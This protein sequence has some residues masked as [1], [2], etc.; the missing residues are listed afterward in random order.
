[1]DEEAAGILIAVAVVVAVVLALFLLLIPEPSERAVIATERLDVAV[2]AF[3]NSS[4]WSSVGETLRARVE[5]KLVNAEGISVFSRVRLDA[6]LTEQALSQTGALD[7]S[8]AVRIGSLTG[9]NKLVAGSVYGVEALSEAVTICERWKDGICVQS[10]PG[11]RYTVKLLAQVE[12]LN[13][14]TGRIEQAHDEEGTANATAKQGEVFAGYDTLIAAAADDIASDVSSF[15]T[16]TYTREIRYGLYRAVKAKGDGFVGEGE[17]TR[18]HRSDAKA[19][20][21][22]HFA[23]VRDDDSFDLT[24]VDSSGAFLSSLQ[25]VVASDDWRLYSLDL[26]KAPLGRITAKGRIAGIDAFAKA[27]VLSP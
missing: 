2:L 27:F 5:T 22:V 15:L 7:P 25:D 18:F 26:E 21:I 9:V 20:L 4:A 1:M 14:Q 23:R 16:L 19:Y 13:A 10:T 8:T 17:T 24:W 6:L 3:G 12:V 11:T